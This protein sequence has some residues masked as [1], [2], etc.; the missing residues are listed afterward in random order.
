M[1]FRSM[2]ESA[3]F[4]SLKNIVIKGK[5]ITFNSVVSAVDLT[6][7]NKNGGTLTIKKKRH[8]PTASAEDRFRDATSDKSY[9]SPI[10][11]RKSH[12]CCLF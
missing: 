7:M 12:L 6:V 1:L 5:D 3:V 4:G 8:T 2:F 9:T 10:R 11:P